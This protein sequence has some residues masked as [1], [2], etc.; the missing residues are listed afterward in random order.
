VSGTTES[1][2]SVFLALLAFRAVAW[3]RRTRIIRDH[4]GEYA[5]CRKRVSLDALVGT[6]IFYL[7]LTANHPALDMQCHEAPYYLI[8]MAI[9]MLYLG[10]IAFAAIQFFTSQRR[11]RRKTCMADVDSVHGISIVKGQPT[12]FSLGTLFYLATISTAFTRTAW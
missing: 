1:G 11:N 6:T 12:A 10:W 4:S 8:F 9:G 7:N 5:H 3:K 2:L